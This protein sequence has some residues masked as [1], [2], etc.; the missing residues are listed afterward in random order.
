MS[1]D[2]LFQQDGA[3]ARVTLNRPDRGNMLTLA[4]LEELSA[5]IERAGRDPDTKAIVLTAEG[6]NFCM[7][8]DPQGAPEGAPRTAVD[9]RKTLTAP[10]LGAY[11]AARGAEVPIVAAVQGSANGFGCALA[12]VS[13]VTIAAHDARFALPE[14]KADLPPTLAMCAHIDRTMTKS[15][16][17]L[18]YS[19][20]QIDAESARALGFVSHVAPPG[21]LDGTVA[22]F[23][24]GLDARSREAIVTCK[25]FLSKA[26]LMEPGQAADYAGNLLAVV[27]SSK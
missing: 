26:R 10:I 1:E 24:D 16:G 12:A 21:E 25:T 15:I 18:V 20:D 5:L 8:R 4:H 14:M 27:M 17:W 23:L 19:M 3:F 2:I 13:D 22:A 7:G 9:M 11:A 6:E